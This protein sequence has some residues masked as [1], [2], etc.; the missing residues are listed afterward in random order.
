MGICV[1]LALQAIEFARQISGLGVGQIIFTDIATDGT[2]TGPNFAAVEKVC[3]AVNCNVIASG[4][5]SQA[6]DIRQLRAL[7]GRRPN[8]L[9][10]IVGKALYDGRIKLVDVL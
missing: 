5:V 2:L 1:G 9:G 3:A 4:G 7:A 10:V 8:L 6:E